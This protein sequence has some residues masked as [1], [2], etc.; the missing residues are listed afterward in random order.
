VRFAES[1]LVWI[2]NRNARRDAARAARYREIGRIPVIVS[3]DQLAEQGCEPAAS[4]ATSCDLVGDLG[5]TAAHLLEANGWPRPRAWAF[6]LFHSTGRD[7]E[8]TCDLL[9]E[10][11]EAVVTPATLRQWKSRHFTAGARIL[12]SHREAL[13]GGK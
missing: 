7:Y 11:F 12:N 13:F 3:L 2:W 10:R 4:T 8:E 1:I 9:A 5:R 6:V